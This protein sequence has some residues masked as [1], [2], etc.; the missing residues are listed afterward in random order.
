MHLNQA[1][2]EFWFDGENTHLS[3]LTPRQHAVLDQVMEEFKDVIGD[4]F[5]RQAQAA[6]K[7]SLCE[8]TRQAELPT[9]KPVAFQEKPQDA[10]ANH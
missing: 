1:I 8:V 9:S 3:A 7:C 2:T 10:E 5:D 6:C 4:E